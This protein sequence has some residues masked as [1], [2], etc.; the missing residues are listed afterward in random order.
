MP[1]GR[2]KGSGKQ[3][4]AV[5]VQ[6]DPCGEIVEDMAKELIPKYHSHLVNCEIAY[7][8]KNKGITVRGRSAA[9]TAEKCSPK[10][11][12]L[13]NYDFL[14][15]ICFED[16]NNLSDAQKWAVLDHELEHCWVEED[17]SG[18]TKCKILPHDFE[19][20]GSILQRHG[21]YSH[22]AVKL[23]HVMDTVPGDHGEIDIDSPEDSEEDLLD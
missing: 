2:P 15:T 21:L 5:P 8:F 3:V 6:Y 9:A 7:L 17:D 20:F 22:T 14:I 19:D 4:K 23:K 10:V 18:E 16:W 12:A 11:K 13:C 1:R